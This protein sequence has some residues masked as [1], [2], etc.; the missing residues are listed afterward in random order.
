[1]QRIAELPPLSELLLQGT[2][3]EMLLEK[4]FD[5][6]PYDVLEKRAISFHC[7]CSREKVERVF[8]AMGQSELQRL[9]DTEEGAEVTCEFCREQYCFDREELTSLLAEL[10]ADSGKQQKKT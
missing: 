8:I 7:S 2:T 4:L 1:M 5:G 10:G 6:I 9:I 3:P